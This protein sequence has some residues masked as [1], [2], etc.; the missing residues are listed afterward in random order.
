MRKALLFIVLLCFGMLGNAQKSN[1]SDS[2][3]FKIQFDY[4]NNYV[5]NGRTDSLTSPYQITTA[6]LHFGKSFYASF[7]ADYLLTNGQN[8][9]DF[10]ELDLGHEYSIGKNI[11]GEL[12]ASKYMYNS[13]SNLLNGNISADL[14]A[15]LNQDLGFIQLNH[16]A[17][18]F[19][20]SGTDFQYS[21][22][23]SKSMDI[24]SENGSWN[25]SPS[26]NA[27]GSTLSYYE[28]VI[29]RKLNPNKGVKNKLSGAT[30]P[31]VNITTTLQDKGFK[32]MASEISLP[33][34]YENKTWGFNCT[35]NYAMPFN[36]VKTN[37]VIKTTLATG[38]TT[39]STVDSTPYSERNLKN[40][41]YFQ[42]GIFFKF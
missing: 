33:I 27:I 14:G 36:Q 18:I 3:K 2:S 26:I 10:F 31:T 5:Y 35:L 28:S 1:N 9:F 15:T 30:L 23:I 37:S 34:S 21:L 32:L 25:F 29:S 24:E 20:S 38:A 4:L 6:T 39:T 16:T 11:T 19:F 22:G 41:F 7:S 17:D 40:V 13:N 12:Y 8:R 42:T